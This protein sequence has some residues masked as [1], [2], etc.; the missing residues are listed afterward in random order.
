MTRSRIR[1]VCGLMAGLM[2]FAASA[3]PPMMKF[4]NRSYGNWVE[5]GSCTYLENGYR[6]R[7][8]QARENYDVKGTFE[9]T[10]ASFNTW[11]Y[12]YDPG[13]G[14]YEESWRVLTCP[15]DPKAISAHPNR[16]TVEVALNP[17]WPG[18]YQW[19]E[20]HTW[21]PIND[22]QWFPNPWTPGTREIEGEWM[23]AFNFGSSIS[24]QKDSFYDGGSGTT[25]R[26]NYN[27]KW[28]WGDMMTRGGFSINTRFYAFEGP[29]APTWSFYQV[30]SCNEKEAQH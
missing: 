22:H 6:C 25:S 10:E 24:N 26:R 19:G 11:S 4:G 12:I 16:V 27:C 7:A 28:N 20:R 30:S 17:E 1:W 21:D 9:F 13:D 3:E 5:G 8:I 23:G 14:S 29:D 2:A 18:C 15:V